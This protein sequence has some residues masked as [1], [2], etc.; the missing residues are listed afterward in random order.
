[1]LKISFGSFSSKAVLLP[2]IASLAYTIAVVFL[3]ELFAELLHIL[4]FGSTD[5]NT[6]IDSV[7]ILGFLL[8]YI[9]RILAGYLS[10]KISR[11]IVWINLIIIWLL[12]VL[13]STYFTNLLINILSFSEQMLSLPI[14]LA[15]FLSEVDLILIYLGA[16]LF[17]K[18]KN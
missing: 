7:F 10:S 11:K 14:V 3:T 17:E 6:L 12:I 9:S 18:R 8:V 15:F 16:Y 13:V 4:I 5:R 1:M 2:F